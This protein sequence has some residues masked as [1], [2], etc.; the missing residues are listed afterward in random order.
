MSRLLSLTFWQMGGSGALLLLPDPTLPA[1][2]A[3]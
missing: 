3:F 1:T 2:G